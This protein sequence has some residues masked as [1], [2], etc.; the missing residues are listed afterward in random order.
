M[1]EF[2]VVMHV[3]EQ[4]NVERADAIAV[5]IA[6]IAE[7]ARE[8]G[9]EPNGRPKAAPVWHA[10]DRVELEPIVEGAS[11]TEP[12]EPA[13]EPAEPA[14]PGAGS[15]GPIFFRRFSRE[16]DGALTVLVLAPSQGLYQGG[17]A[18]P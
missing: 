5:D 2:A 7:T 14:S 13:V 10:T 15:S 12:P 16:A 1:V 8:A 11:P 4:T 18:P 3:L 17:S 6:R 9:G